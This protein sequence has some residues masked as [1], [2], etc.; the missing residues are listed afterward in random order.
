MRSGAAAP[1]TCPLLTLYVRPG[2]LGGHGGD[3]TTDE[4][5][6]ISGALDMRCARRCL[7]TLLRSPSGCSHKTVA[8]AMTPIHRVR[9]VALNTPLTWPHLRAIVGACCAPRLPSL[10]ALYL[11]F[12]D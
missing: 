8:S 3:L 2:A 11:S 12:T 5:T 6:I 7:A 10:P 1:R 4:T 9:S